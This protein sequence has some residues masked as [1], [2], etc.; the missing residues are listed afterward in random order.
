MATVPENFFE[1]ADKGNIQF[2]RAS[3]WWFWSGG[4]EFDDQSK[5]EA[6]VVILATGYDGKKKLISLLPEPFRSLVVDS[7]GVMPLYR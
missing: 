2:K 4:I 5:L 1:E 6:D 3:N 7:T